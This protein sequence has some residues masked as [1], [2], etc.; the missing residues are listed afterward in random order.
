MKL[1][2]QSGNDLELE[3]LWEKVCEGNKKALE[4]LFR[5]TFD[6]LYRYGYRIIPNS[7]NVR[8]AIQEVFFQIWKYRENLEKPKSVKAYIFISLRREL[9]NKKKA[10]QRRD[11]I[12]SKYQKE[13]FDL[14]VNFGNWE[15][16]LD[17]EGE[18]GKELKKA[19]EKLSA[20]QREVIY[21]KYFEGMLTEEISEILQVRSQSIYN[22]AFD[23]IKN[24]RK[25]LDKG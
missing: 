23:A 17:L 6:T 8:D 13:S 5:Q 1:N 9:L 15:Q 18:Q 11:E 21:L 12:D 14:L 10:D 4:Q 3:L 2:Q 22:L 20:S 24:L 7:E 19:I 25:F 16:I